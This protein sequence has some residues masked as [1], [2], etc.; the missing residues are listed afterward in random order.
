MLVV[1]ELVLRQ[2]VEP[3]SIAMLLRCSKA[4]SYLRGDYTNRYTSED[5]VSDGERPTERGPEDAKDGRQVS[6]AVLR[7]KLR[8]GRYSGGRM[9]DGGHFFKPAHV[10]GHQKQGGG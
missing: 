2:G 8:S 4:L 3:C 5:D 6:R 10:R 9:A 7:G 1:H